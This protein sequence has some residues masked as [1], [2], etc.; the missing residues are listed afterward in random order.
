MNSN[1]TYLRDAILADENLGSVEIVLDLFQQD[2]NHTLGRKALKL[3]EDLTETL[4]THKACV[5][6]AEAINTH[7]RH[8]CGVLHRFST[9]CDSVIKQQEAWEEGILEK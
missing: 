1:R 8:H 5:A 7:R 2:S 6:M 9:I 3:I 4:G